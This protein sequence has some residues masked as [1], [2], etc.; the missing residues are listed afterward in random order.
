MVIRLINFEFRGNR[1]KVS[2]ILSSLCIIALA[3][4][5]HWRFGTLAHVSLIALA[6]GDSVSQS[7]TSTGLTLQIAGGGADPT[8]LPKATGQAPPDAVPNVNANS[9][10]LDPTSGVKV[11][12]ATSAS[13][14]CGANNG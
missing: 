6:A 7:R 5:S 10:Y 3:T 2:L 13:Y 9:Y 14:P 8:M 11:W 1:M 12:R 4:F